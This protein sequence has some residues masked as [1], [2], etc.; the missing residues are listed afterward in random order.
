[1][2]SELWDEIHEQPDRLESVID[3]NRRQVSRVGALID[4]SDI[5]WVL[6]AARG[7]SD[8]AARYAQYVWGARNGLAVA[9]AAPSLFGGY[10]QPPS[11]EGALVVGISQSGQSPDLVGVL[12]EARRR[13]RPTLAIT[14]D[15]DSPLASAADEVLALYAGEERAVA[16]TK[17]YTC[18]LAVVAMLSEALAGEPDPGASLADLPQQVAAA[19]ELSK[20]LDSAA[21][22]LAEDDRCAVLARGFQHATAFEWALK[23]Q[24]LAQVLA[25]PYST[26]DFRHGPMALVEP[27]FPVLAIATAGEL[28]DDVDELIQSVA[29]R[30]AELLVLSDRPD[31]HPPGSVVHLAPGVPEWLVPI[32][33]VVAAQL[34]TYHLTRARG[35]DPDAPRGLRKVTRTV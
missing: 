17:T 11:L 6:I 30:G 21:A 26:A 18:Q 28:E 7:T 33:T 35:L 4:G 25:Q 31:H 12:E 2:S 29:E 8:N 19:L 16:A 13:R 9:S 32:P 22:P 20:E 10:S 15:P 23:L 34:A 24:E 3:G 5:G 1:M 27:G 14:N